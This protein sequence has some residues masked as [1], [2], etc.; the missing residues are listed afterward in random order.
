MVFFSSLLERIKMKNKIFLLAFMLFICGSVKAQSSTFNIYLEPLTVPGLGG[1]QAYAY[2]QDNGKWL[3]IGGRLDGLHRRQ[4][5]AAFDLAGHN[6]QL[7]VIDPNS[8]QKWAA[9]LTSLPVALQ[10][11]LSSTNMEFH[12]HGNMLY[13]IGGYGYSATAGDHTTYPNLTAV[14]VSEVIDAIIQGTPFNGHFRQI[15][16]TM[17]AVTGGYLNKINDTYYLTGG[18]KFIGRYNPMGPTHGPG[19]FQEYTNAIRKFNIQDDGTNLSITHLPG[20]TDAA[21]L[22]RDASL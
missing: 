8:Q 13:I 17:F 15:T 14:K 5:F 19:F 10:E 11:Q 7:L 22:H 2:G 16:D 1:L 12:Q 9:P 3:I 4:P 20:F 21:N 6:N 18:Q